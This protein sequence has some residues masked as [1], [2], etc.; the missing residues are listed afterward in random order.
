MPISFGWSKSGESSLN[1]RHDLARDDYHLCRLN[2]S[3]EGEVTPKAEME[4][5]GAQG[6][7]YVS[8]TRERIRSALSERQ[9][10]C[11]PGDP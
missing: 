11:C 4:V 3:K 10:C 5:K 9:T 1:F 2:G 7:W 6:K 8:G